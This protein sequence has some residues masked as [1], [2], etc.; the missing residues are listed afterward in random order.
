MVSVC[1]CLVFAVISL[2]LLVFVFELVFVVAQSCLQIEGNS[3]C[4]QVWLL[5]VFALCFVFAVDVFAL[6]LPLCWCFCFYC[7]L[8]YMY[9]H[10]YMCM[11][12]LSVHIDR[13]CTDTHEY[14][15]MH[16]CINADVHIYM[17]THIYLCLYIYIYICVCVRV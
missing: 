12:Y 6:C 1:R 15:C 13:L 3:P 7:L 9:V 5:T 8:M 2:C 10:I 17:Y 16:V 14:V 4:S 11:P